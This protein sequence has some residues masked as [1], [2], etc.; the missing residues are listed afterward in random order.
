LSV[1]SLIN[2]KNLIGDFHSDSFESIALEVF[3]FQAKHN[4][5]YQS[6]LTHLGITP[7]EIKSIN[8]IP[9]LPIEF[10]KS[11]DVKTGSW[12]EENNFLSS[13]T[14]SALRSSHS[15]ED[16]K[17]YYKH[18]QNIYEQF[19]P[20]LTDTT[21]LALLPSYIEQGGSGLVCMIDAFIKK[22][23]SENS[24]YYLNNYKEL[25]IALIEAL[26]MNKPVVLF[27]VTYAL[28]DFARKATHKFDQ[29]IVIETGGMK[30]RGE[31]L[32]KTEVHEILKE[33]LGVD[34]IHSEYGMTELMSQAYSQGEGIFE[35]PKSMKVV[36]KDINDPFNTM[37]NE[38]VGIVNIIDLA[39]VHSCCFVETKDIG[40]KY[41]NGRFEILG[42]ID[43]SEARGC[44]MLIS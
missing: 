18:T 17:F 15:I 9:F 4:S 20:K 26:D 41:S 27:G 23:T 5:I 31:E 12:V 44:N 28:L 35:S 37:K 8:E 11:F 32:T 24:G 33:E 43:N 19:Y 21:V 13:G 39:N 2:F 42:R 40:K 25:E 29:L 22:S 14:T 6:Y 1:P 30:G 16:L 3:Q 34:K 7:L 36:I 38:H 10:F